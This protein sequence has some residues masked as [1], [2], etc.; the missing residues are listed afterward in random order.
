MY[1]VFPPSHFEAILTSS[2]LISL[3]QFSTH[4]GSSCIQK[5]K[6]SVRIALCRFELTGISHRECSQKNETSTTLESSEQ[7]LGVLIGFSVVATG[8]FRMIVEVEPLFMF[9]AVSFTL[10]A[11]LV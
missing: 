9:I 8:Y 3:K 1:F 6:T 2:A 4:W 7:K 5:I 10:F 11:G